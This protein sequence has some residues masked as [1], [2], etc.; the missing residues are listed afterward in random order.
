M[1]YDFFQSN[2]NQ[3]QNIKKIKNYIIIKRIGFGSSGLVYQVYDNNDPNKKILILKQIPFRNISIDFEETTRKLKEAKNESLI[4]SKLDFK[5]VVKYYDS[6]IEEDCLNIIMEFCEEGDFGSFI[7]N[8]IQKRSYLS[9]QQIWHFFIQISLGLAYI[10]SKNILHRDLKPMNIFLKKNNLIK[11][12]DLGVAKLL[13]TNTK[14]NTYIGTPYYL[15]PEVCEGKAYNSKSDVWAL[16]CILYEMCTFKKPFNA[17]NQAALCMKIIEGKYKPLNKFGNIPKYSKKLEYMINYMLK[18]DCME[19]PLMKEIMSN[20]IFFEKTVILGY[21]SDIKRIYNNYNNINLKNNIVIKNIQINTNLINDNSK[22]QCSNR[23]TLNDKKRSI[24]AKSRENKIKR[25]HSSGICVKK[26]KTIQ[27][28][29]N[30]MSKNSKNGSSKYSCKKYKTKY[31]IFPSGDKKKSN[32]MG[33]KTIET[34]H[35]YHRNK[36]NLDNN[37]NMLTTI[38]NYEENKTKCI[39]P[40]QRSKKVM[41]RN[42]LIN[43]FNEN[44][45]LIKCNSNYYNISSINNKI[46]NK[47]DTVQEKQK[48]K[49]N[50]K[51]LEEREIINYIHKNN[52]K[53]NIYNFRKDYSFQK[54]N[55]ISNKKE[56]YKDNNNHK[57]NNIMNILENNNNKNIYNLNKK[58]IKIISIDKKYKSINKTSINNSKNKTRKKIISNEY[59]NNPKKI[60]R[61]ER[62]IQNG[63]LGNDHQSSDNLF[64]KHKNEIEIDNINNNFNGTQIQLRKN[65]MKGKNIIDKYSP[66]YFR[67][68]SFIKDYKVTTE[69]SQINTEKNNNNK[70]I[71]NINNNYFNLNEDNKEMILF[72][73]KPKIEELFTITKI[74]TSDRTNNN[75]LNEKYYQNNFDNSNNEISITKTEEDNDD[76]EEKVSVLKEQNSIMKE[77]INQKKE[78]YLNKYNEIKNNL[79]K[80]KN[81]IDT[82]KLFTLYELISKDKDKSEKIFKQIENYIVT[83]LPQEF[84]KQFHKLF[85][86]FIFYD[87]EIGNIKRLQDKFS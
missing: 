45:K 12:G 2:Y 27:N 62:I 48:Q 71:K 68:N 66:S 55:L 84:Y 81:V 39:I 72:N 6:F 76:N 4:L 56:N 8:L 24:P 73:E 33:K 46:K 43:N 64:K 57:K 85:N 38:N 54:S 16:G 87:I 21:E 53:N 75:G 74:N 10:H 67:N 50:N 86:K 17:F 36:K 30:I 77:K 22:E 26:R 47:K 65:T 9:E 19:R 78:E 1:S 80:Y 79:L 37:I 25:V 3:N 41:I 52:N 69:G 13:Q 40:R 31:K 20:K 42:N 32:S 83:N 49:E 82:E 5:Y 14:A 59:F 15:S 34:S 61:E 51:K 63:V 58:G 7:S 23:E 29:I 28:S 35:N 60:K 11:I 18:R 44:P 70:N